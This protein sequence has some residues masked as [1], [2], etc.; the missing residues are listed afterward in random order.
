V[1][2]YHPLQ[3]LWT[4]TTGITGLIAIVVTPFI[5]LPMTVPYLKKRVSFEWRKLLHYL[6]ILWGTALM[7]HAPQRIFWLI[8]VPMFIYATDKVVEVIFKTHLTESAYFQRLGESSCIIS[9]ENPPG[10]GKQNSA[11][12]YLM[13]P[14]LSKYQFHAFT[15]FPCS[16]PNHSSICIHK[17]GDWTTS[18]MNTITTPTH[19]PAFVV[20]P[21]LSPFSSP[22][23]DSENLVAVA[24]GIGVTPAISL[25]KQY[26]NTSRRLNLIWI[27][28]DPGLI[29]HF[30]HNVDFGCD[31]YILIYYTGKER[32]LVLGDGIPPNIFI[33]NGRPNLERT[34][35]G[36]IVS[37]A[38]GTCLPEHLLESVVV[39]QTPAKMRSK[40]LL[41][42]AL[43]I[44]N[45]DQLYE[46]T[47]KASIFYN[48][49]IEPTVGT[50]HYRGVLSTMRHLLGDDFQLVA[51]QITTNFERVDADGDC[52]LNRIEF[53][54]FF[55]LMLLGSGSTDEES[56]MAT[57]KSGIHQMSTCRDLF[58]SNKDVAESDSEKWNDEFGL[59]KHLQGNGKFAA[60]NWKMLYCGG[61]R[62]I[63][64]KLKDF[65]RKF[66]VGLSVEKFD[67]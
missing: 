39:T 36:I 5:V 63:K 45:M 44:Y 11:Y 33:F 7:F 31:G 64:D 1:P 56:V 29:E 60:K 15:V 22:A 25:I 52:L 16:K 42:K 50:V 57:I 9:F 12:V 8:G 55:N 67:W 4:T 59:T 28:R 35:S 24:S 37:I 14:W 32:S 13:L 58:D 62:P 26:S 6:S 30:L 47:T 49:T 51:D 23:M 18:L 21:F 2:F 40:L 66:G 17:C 53:E 61:S 19:K 27:C 54:E 10:F 3:L 38:A 41:E 34:I 43:S 48:E 46:Y 65:E 20:G